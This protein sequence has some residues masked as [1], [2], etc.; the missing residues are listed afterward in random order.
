MVEGS[1]ID[2]SKMTSEQRDDNSYGSYDFLISMPIY[3]LTK[4]KVDDLLKEKEKRSEE[5]ALLKA[6]T[7]KD[8]WE[9][10]L[11]TFEVEYKKHMDEYYEYM[12]IDPKEIKNNAVKGDMKKVVM[13]KK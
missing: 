1:L 10:D 11:K 9:E 7:D 2:L 4:E 6:K 8:I 5:L 12:G 3:N 13:K